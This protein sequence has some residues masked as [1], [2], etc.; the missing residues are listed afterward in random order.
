MGLRDELREQPDVARRLL[1]RSHAVFAR[2]AEELRSRPPRFVVIAARGSSDHA[3]LYAQ[4][5]LGVRNGLVVALATPSTITLYGARPRMAEALVLGIS[6]SGQ[7][8][9]IVAVLDEARRQGALTIAVTNDGSSPLAGAA[10]EVIELHAGPELA[11]A[12]TKTYTAQLL[13]A[14]LLSFSLTAPTADERRA[15]AEL[16]D[17]MEAALAAEPAAEAIAAGHAALERAVVLGRGFEYATARE[18]AL[19]LQELAQLMAHPFSA[20]DFEHGPLALAERDFPVLA[21]AP[22]GAAGQAQLPLLRKL[23][24]EHQA[25]LLVISDD[26]EVLRLDQGLPLPTGVPAWLGPLVSVIPAQLYA[27]HLTRA[28]GLDTERLRGI[29]KVTS[30]R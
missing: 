9:D 13:A 3:A 7:S 16:P 19:K 26:E 6:Q 17:Q 22:A 10:A 18:W 4:Y 2:L 5:L 12:A 11:T 27:Y 1:E 24:D 21:V 29:R 23:R 15:L 8:E 25:R 28:K 30:T 20:A 14:A